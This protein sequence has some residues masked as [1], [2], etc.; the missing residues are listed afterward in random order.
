M[1][2]IPDDPVISRIMATGYPPCFHA[3]GIDDCDE[4][5]EDIADD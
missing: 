2:Q 4:D 3:M 1:I 5:T